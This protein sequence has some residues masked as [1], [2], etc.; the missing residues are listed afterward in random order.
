M[1][2]IIADDGKGIIIDGIY[3]KFYKED[4]KDGESK[5]GEWIAWYRM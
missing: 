2:I 3:C 4:N 5:Y 1:A